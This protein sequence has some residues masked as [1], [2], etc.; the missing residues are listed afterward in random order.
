MW[1][2]FGF[3]KCIKHYI[4]YYNTC[5]IKGNITRFAIIEAISN[6]LFI[7]IN[8]CVHFKNSFKKVNLISTK[9]V[10]KWELEFKLS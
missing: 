10:R 5:L 7:Y 4:T 8:R 9:K 2:N 3:D 6:F 1:L